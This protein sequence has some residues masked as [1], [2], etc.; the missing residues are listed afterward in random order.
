MRTAFRLIGSFVAGALVTAVASMCAGAITFATGLETTIPGLV[1]VI[2][3]EGELSA[4]LTLQPTT[5]VWVMAIALACN[6]VALALDQRSETKAR[7]Q[8]DETTTRS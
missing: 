4:D 1:R 8:I 5:P 6:A 2:P 7:R 3:G